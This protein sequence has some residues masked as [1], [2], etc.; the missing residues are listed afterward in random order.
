MSATLHGVVSLLRVSRGGAGA[1][2]QLQVYKGRMY[3]SLGC[4]ARGK[5]LLSRVSTQLL[6][7]KMP[8][9]VLLA[10]IGFRCMRRSVCCCSLR[11]ELGLLFLVNKGL[12]SLRA[13][14]QPIWR[15]TAMLLLMH[16]S[17]TPPNNPY[18][19]NVY[20]HAIA[21]DARHPYRD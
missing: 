10:W 19:S 6:G 17:G 3:D 5:D 8:P 18:P 11:I 4:L 15:A 2:K 21:Y 14:Q 7:C 13:L 9:R 1:R 12:V 16:S 20:T